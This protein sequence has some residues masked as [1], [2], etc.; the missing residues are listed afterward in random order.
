M[1]VGPP[2]AGQTA[3]SIPVRARSRASQEG[4]NLLLLLVAQDVGHPGGRPRARC[5][6]QRPGALHQLAEY[7]V[8]RLSNADRSVDGNGARRQ[9]ERSNSD[10]SQSSIR[11]LRRIG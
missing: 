1:T 11:A 8:A 10:L 6:R 9:R 2:Q 7:E 3:R 4:Q 5:L